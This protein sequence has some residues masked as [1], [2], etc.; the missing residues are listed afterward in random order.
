M[1][2]VRNIRLGKYIDFVINYRY[3]KR[4]RFYTGIY[5]GTSAVLLQCVSNHSNIPYTVIP[6]TVGY[7]IGAHADIFLPLSASYLVLIA[8]VRLAYYIMSGV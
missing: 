6:F 3:T 7:I 1:E 8:P 5:L 4:Q 2:F